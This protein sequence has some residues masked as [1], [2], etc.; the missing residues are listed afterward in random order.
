MDDLFRFISVRPAQSADPSKTVSIS[1]NTPFQEEVRSNFNTQTPPD[2]RW[3]IAFRV[4][5]QQFLHY[6]QLITDITSLA[7]YPQYHALYSRLAAQMAPGAT[8]PQPNLV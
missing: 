2:Q 6:P 1:G 5:E 4:A 7:R 3:Q 8:G